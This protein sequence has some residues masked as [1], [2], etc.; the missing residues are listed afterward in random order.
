[1]PISD[2]KPLINQNPLLQGYYN[3]LESRIGYRLVLGGT[4]HFGYYE[5][6]TYWPFP[7]NAALRAMEDRLFSNLNL[8][9][10]SKVLDAGCGVGNVA[11]RMAQSGLRIQA[12]DVVKH[13]VEKA[14]R[15]I[16]RRGWTHA[17]DVRRM[18][19][20]HLDAF[21]EATF[22]GAYTMETFVHATDPE[23]VLAGFFRVLK[24]GGSMVLFEY[25]HSNLSAAPN[26]L[27]NTWKEINKYSAMPFYDSNDQGTLEQLL[28]K[29]GFVDVVVQDYTTN[30]TPMLRLFFVLAYIPYL[31]VRLFGLQA[32]FVNIAAGVEGYR[33]I[34]YARYVAVSAKKPLV[35]LPSEDNTE[36]NGL[37]E[38]NRMAP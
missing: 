7:I 19:Y 11:L 30:V 3:S 37:R 27:K 8:K 34:G 35:S 12:I 9:A 1:M 21:E 22:D 16:Q 17:I 6:D 28:K 2:R 10:G 5:K 36:S 25:E 13:H 24:P 23:V 14:K 33:S 32:Y 29:T 38:R 31:I 20:H 15:N 26:G 4:R 18:D